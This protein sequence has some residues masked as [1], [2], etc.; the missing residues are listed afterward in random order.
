VYFERASDGAHGS[1]SPGWTSRVALSRFDSVLQRCITDHLREGF[2]S[3]GATP[4]AASRLGTGVRTA[5]PARTQPLPLA[6]DPADGERRIEAALLQAQIQSRARYLDERLTP[7]QHSALWP[8]LR[9]IIQLA[10]SGAP[11]AQLS[12]LRDK[13]S[14]KTR[15]LGLREDTR[16]ELSGLLRDGTKLARLGG[17]APRTQPD[18]TP[19]A[20]S[21]AKARPKAPSKPRR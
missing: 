8:L 6:A 9:S 11:E 10:M 1:C 15:K 12:P 19:A 14:A 4:A 20:A 21:G 5:S 17:A 16:G 18:A 3:M 13:I 7:E 2:V